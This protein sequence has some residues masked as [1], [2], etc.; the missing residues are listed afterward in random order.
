MLYNSIY[1]VY[2]IPVHVQHNYT[3]TVYNITV[4]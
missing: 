1:T 4:I 3:Y 2:N